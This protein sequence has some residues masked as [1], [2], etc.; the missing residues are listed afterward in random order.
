MFRHC[1]RSLDQL[2]QGLDPDLAAGLPQ[3]WQR[4]LFGRA[5][6]QRIAQ[7]K[8]PFRQLKLG[9]LS[10]TATWAAF[11]RGL[12]QGQTPLDPGEGRRIASL[13]SIEARLRRN[14]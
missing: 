6:R 3:G 8:P 2:D 4:R 13:L 12:T 1:L 14:S 5:L 9:L 11:R 7:L 10:A